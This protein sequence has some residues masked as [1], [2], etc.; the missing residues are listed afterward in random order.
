MNKWIQKIVLTGGPSAGKSTA[1]SRVVE[2]VNSLGVMAVSVPEAATELKLNGITPQSYEDPTL[3]QDFLIEKLLFNEG[4]FM[5]ALQH[6]YG[7]WRCYS[8]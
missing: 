6:S 7:K 1:I 3:F 2:F 8:L 5:R 4:F